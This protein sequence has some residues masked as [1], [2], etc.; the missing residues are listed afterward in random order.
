MVLRTL[1]SQAVI[2]QRVEEKTDEQP[3]LTNPDLMGTSDRSSQIIVVVSSLLWRSIAV[4][5]F[6][7]C[8]PSSTATKHDTQP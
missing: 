2:R 5:K 7:S 8:C 3:T 6:V 4:V 1:V